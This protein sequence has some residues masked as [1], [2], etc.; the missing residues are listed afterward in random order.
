MDIIG[1]IHPPSDKGHHFILVA[2]DYFSKWAEVVPL[3]K[4]KTN[5]VINFVKNH[6]ICRFGVPGCL[7]HD[8]GPQV[9]NDKF[10]RF[11]DKYGIYCCTST[12]YILAA[13][14]LAEAFNKTICKILKKMV[15][16]NKKS[17]ETKLPKAL[18]AY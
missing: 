8:N 10:Y 18:W 2:I 1:K 4:V 7:Y 17:W 3:T 6:I 5:S 12:A 14:G 16:D 15:S 9:S 13:N 11:C